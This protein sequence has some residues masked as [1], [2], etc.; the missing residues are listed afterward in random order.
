MTAAYRTPDLTNRIERFGKISAV[1]VRSRTVADG[2]N[3]EQPR[4]SGDVAD[5]DNDRVILSWLSRRMP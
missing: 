1:P 2:W 5:L 4:N 3:G